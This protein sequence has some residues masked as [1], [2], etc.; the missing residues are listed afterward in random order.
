MPSQITIG[1]PHGKAV[2]DRQ[3]PSV[4]PFPQT[5]FPCSAYPVALA[6]RT[7]ILHDICALHAA[8]ALVQ[9]LFPH[10]RVC[11]QRHSS[12]GT[13]GRATGPPTRR[14]KRL[15]WLSC[16]PAAVTLP[17]MQSIDC[18]LARNISRKNKVAF[19]PI[20]P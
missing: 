13:G 19:H 2:G 9:H 20:D 18:G 3:L 14:A 12:D 7:H 1:S 5:K 16:R 11:I 8:S 15:A 17:Q 10:N 4:E 6:L